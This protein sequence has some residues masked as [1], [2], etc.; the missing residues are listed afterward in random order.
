MGH[1][2]RDGTSGAM[3]AGLVLAMIVGA[4]SFAT[5]SSRAADGPPAGATASADK[6]V[7]PIAPTPPAAVA[8][9][10]APAKPAIAARVLFG[11]VKTPAPLAARAIGSYSRGCLAGGK[12][13]PVD[14]PEWQAMRLSRNRN[15]G[16][17]ELVSFIER[18][19][20]DARRFEGWP[21]LLVG[22]MSQPRGGPM[23]SSHASHQI[24]LD[25]DIWFVP[26]PDHRLTR[27]QREET[28]ADSM[29]LPDKLTLDPKVWSETHVRLLKRAASF[30]EVE[31]IFVAP[32]IKKALCDATL[33]DVD[34]TWLHK[35]RPLW[36]H[37]DHFHVRIKCPDGVAGCTAQAP[38][39]TDDGCGKEV[40]DWLALV[41]RPPDPNEKPSPPTPPL[42]LDKL[43]ED[44]RQVLAA[45]GKTPINPAA[46]PAKAAAQQP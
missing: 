37:N 2:G 1:V 5:D 28:S 30:G 24:G 39:A 26:M 15:W 25:V 12:A 17:P 34:R 3:T 21:G 27:Q 43:P 13:L 32:A 42:T 44:C 22:D 19:A 14:G 40:T 29:V 33:K 35:V 36:G 16:T 38:T 9:P 23:V 41:T 31:R 11:A 18:F 46:A 45:P 4:T 7:V 10:A 8:P 6:I 20:D